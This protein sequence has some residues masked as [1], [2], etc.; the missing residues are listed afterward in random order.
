MSMTLSLQ[1]EQPPS[2][3]HPSSTSMINAQS[4]QHVIFF[5][6][7]HVLYL[8]KILQDAGSVQC[9]HS[10]QNH[11]QNYAI[12]KRIFKC[13]LPHPATF[14][15]YSHPRPEG[16]KEP[17]PIYILLE[18]PSQKR[19]KRCAKKLPPEGHVAVGCSRK[20]LLHPTNLGCIFLCIL[21][22]LGLG[23]TS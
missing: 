18:S 23:C 22:I 20:M 16:S 6:F 10:H 17:H 13:H 9:T 15:S 1:R 3:P 21:V 19:K 2:C 5:I 4:Q 7:L 12:F 11:S 8:Y 14:T